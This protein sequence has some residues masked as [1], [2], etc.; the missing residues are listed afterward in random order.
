MSNLL[1]KAFYW[2]FAEPKQPVPEPQKPD[3]QPLKKPG[4]TCRNC[5]QN[6][7]V[8][9]EVPDVVEPYIVECYGTT[10]LVWRLF[11]PDGEIH[12]CPIRPLPEHE[13]EVGDKTKQPLKK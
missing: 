3:P 5:G 1:S 7:F 13:G 6:G 8:W 12:K 2:L 4:I 9:K 11:K 10:P